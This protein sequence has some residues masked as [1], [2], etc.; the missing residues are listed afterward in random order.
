MSIITLNNPQQLLTALEENIFIEELVYKGKTSE[1]LGACFANMEGLRRIS[2]GCNSKYTKRHFADY[3]LDI[4]NI[5]VVTL[6]QDAVFTKRFI[7][8]C[9]EKP[10]FK[11]LRLHYPGREQIECLETLYAEGALE[12]FTIVE[13]LSADLIP[14]VD[15]ERYIESNIP[16]PESLHNV[17]KVVRFDYYMRDIAFRKRGKALSIEMV[18][19]ELLEVLKKGDRDAA[20]SKLEDL[21]RVGVTDEELASI[22]HF[23]TGFLEF[24]TIHISNDTALGLDHLWEND[25]FKAVLIYMF[26]QAKELDLLNVSQEYQV[27][28]PYFTSIERLNFVAQY[29]GFPVDAFDVGLIEYPEDLEVLILHNV[30]VKEHFDMSCFENLR[31]L[32]L[33]CMP[34][35]SLTFPEKLQEVTLEDNNQFYLLPSSFYANKE[36]VY[37]K[38]SGELIEFTDVFFELKELKHIF[39]SFFGNYRFDLSMKIAELTHLESLIV[40]SLEGLYEVPSSIC[41]LK[42][43]HTLHLYGKY[44]GI[45]PDIL[46]LPKLWNISLESSVWT[47][48][49][50]T[51]NECRAMFIQLRGER[52]NRVPL[53]QIVRIG[54]EFQFDSDGFRFSDFVPFFVPNSGIQ[55]RPELHKDFFEV[56]LSSPSNHDLKQKDIELFF[57]MLELDEEQ[58]VY[59]FMNKLDFFN[60]DCRSL[61]DIPLSRWRNRLVVLGESSMPIEMLKLHLSKIGI[62][63]TD[64]ITKSTTHIL[65][66]EGAEY[67]EAL[68]GRRDLIYCSEPELAAL[69]ARN[70][71]NQLLQ[72]GGEAMVPQIEQLLFSP[73]ETNRTLA[74]EM[75][76]TLGVPESLHLH[77]LALNKCST[78]RKERRATRDLLRIYCKDKGVLMVLDDDR[79]MFVAKHGHANF[80]NIFFGL[81]NH[82]DWND[83]SDQSNRGYICVHLVWKISQN[84]EALVYLMNGVEQGEVVRQIPYFSKIWFELQSDSD[85]HLVY[86]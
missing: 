27:Y 3:V 2:L 86:G 80:E 34:F 79:E 77:I 49:P 57:G 44:D 12:G 5:E 35:R 71:M 9:R 78:N 33:T 82:A 46:R 61:I 62:K 70:G 54:S 72:D 26:S 41:E 36:L 69:F 37:F 85:K 22:I 11:C 29:T 39:F 81:N 47:V 67:D 21:G 52:L 58:Y 16:L 38:F 18:E 51:L 55:V 24:G 43:L 53:Q 30:V 13:N 28:I 66:G 68:K 19:Q 50:H 59:D 83:V 6:L 7:D 25:I 76:K 45:D 14:F 1:A 10:S 60:P 65:I 40:N 63:L 23:V 20:F 84:V 8:G 4:P 56:L 17:A 31:G 48:V 75:L 73:V 64:E 32:F 74:L 42:Q 15:D